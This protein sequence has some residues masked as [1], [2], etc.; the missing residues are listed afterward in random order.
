LDTTLQLALATGLRARSRMSNSHFGLAEPASKGPSKVTIR[1][2][3]M[4][5][6][7]SEDTP[8]HVAA[9]A[10]GVKES[11]RRYVE[12]AGAI[13]IFGS[14]ERAGDGCFVFPATANSD[15]R[16]GADG[17][18]R[19]QA[20]FSGEVLFKAHG[21]ALNVRLTD[22]VLEIGEK[23]LVFMVAE[24]GGRSRRAEFARLNL[25]EAIGT[26]LGPPRQ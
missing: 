7:M 25:A 11:F 16:I 20:A 1:H 14:A 4:G 21:G 26:V 19:G 23:A 8:L 12:A 9:L 10:W 13:E 6:R 22:P 3:G 17:I 2:H 5:A 18:L 15:L 24:S